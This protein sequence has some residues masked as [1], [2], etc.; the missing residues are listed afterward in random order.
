MEENENIFGEILKE[1]RTNSGL[2][3]D[4]I[5]YDLSENVISKATLSR[6]ER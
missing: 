1:L 3:L 2:A 4:M 6:Y 5:E